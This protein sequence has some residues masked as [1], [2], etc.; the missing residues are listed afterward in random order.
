MTNDDSEGLV[1]HPD[2]GRL[3]LRLTLGVLLLFHGVSKLIGGIDGITGG[4]SKAGVPGALGYLVYIGEVVAP[5]LLIVGIFSRIGAILVVIN[6]I[7]ALLLVHSSQLFTLSKTG[8]YGL[9]LQAFYL[10]TA[11]AVFLLGAGRY[12]L[13][14]ARGRWN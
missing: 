10:L 14:G 4:L 8:G 12:S 9:E 1:H 7:V 5:I 3:V 11:V 13:G 6:M 2:G